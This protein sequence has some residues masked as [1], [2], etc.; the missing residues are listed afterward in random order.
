MPA[1]PSFADRYG[2]WA[3]VAG[4]SE[5]IGLAF[6]HA[7]AERGLNLVL[8]A[9]RPGPLEAAATELRARWD[10]EVQP[11]PCDLAELG[12]KAVRERMLASLSE[13]E[14]GLLVYNAAYSPL[15]DFLDRDLDDAL[16]AL[17]VN[18]RAPMI[19]THALGAAMAARGRGGVIWMGS[20]AGL[21]GSPRLAAYAGTKAFDRSF[22][23]SLY[24][25]L[26]ARGVDV[27]ACVAGATQTPGFAATVG[28]DAGAAPVMQPEA[29]V[30]EA[31]AALGQVPS[32]IVGRGNRAAASVLGR[33]PRWLQVALMD[34]LGPR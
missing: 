31:L 9:R 27:L 8:L 15:G 22:A 26:R 3:L 20:L 34:Q 28:E 23:E 29:V 32:V 7:L 11:T 13:R 21:Q 10:V 16:K 1:P 6:A 24:G 4:A 12:D 33:L 19:L 18:A 17:D 2:P 14:I 25:E 30:R 5:G